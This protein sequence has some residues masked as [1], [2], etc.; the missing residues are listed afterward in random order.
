MMHAARVRDLRAVA[1]AA[2]ATVA[3][4]LAPAAAR[5]DVARTGDEPWYR[6][7]TPEA[8]QRAGVLFA[9]AVDKHQQL[10]RADATELYEQAL[11]VWDNPDIRWNLALAFEQLGKYL[12]AHQQLASALRW[13]EALGSERLGQVLALMRSLETE[14][15]ARIEV[16]SDETGA[17][18]SLDGQPWFRGSGHRVTHVI[19][20]THYIGAT[21]P[22]HVPTTV[23]MIVAAGQQQRVTL[24]MVVDHDVETR[25][26]SVWPQWTVIALGGAVA[27]VG[28]GLEWQASRHRDAAARELKQRCD[29]AVCEPAN[30]PSSERAAMD[31]KR[32][33]YAFGASG[34]VI[35]AGLVV[36]WL[37]RLQPHRPAPVRSPVEIVPDV[38]PAGAG[39][40]ARLRF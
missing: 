36:V 37:N 6:L 11:E 21:Q 1:A 18:V 8:Q 22:G 9:S 26:W 40:S 17:D 5:A 27:A 33:L 19:A 20:G 14:R 12:L 30:T 31:H 2:L 10:L 16:R 23:S 7:A 34:S 24:R 35:A 29:M 13:G 32:A 3:L 15:L 38:S 25:R 28:V 39:I 4:V